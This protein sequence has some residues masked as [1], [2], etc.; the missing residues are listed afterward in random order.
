[1]TIR[2]HRPL[3]A[4]HQMSGL[5]QNLHI[6][7]CRLVGYRGP[8]RVW[9]AG[10]AIRAAVRFLI[11]PKGSAMAWTLPPGD[12]PVLVV[13]TDCPVCFSAGSARRGV[14][15]ICGADV[16]PL[17]DEHAGESELLRPDV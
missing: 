10:A 1:M 16:N 3:T 7:F 12:D 6:T 5:Q 4:A 14:C 9:Q 15:D 8:A 11:S 13:I 17:P 2:S